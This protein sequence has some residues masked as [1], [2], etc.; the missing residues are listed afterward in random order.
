MRATPSRNVGGRAWG[1]AGGGC[2]GGARSRGMEQ[3]GLQLGTNL[4]WE[5]FTRDSPFILSV[6][7]VEIL[8]APESQGAAR[9]TPTPRSCTHPSWMLLIPPAGLDPLIT[10]STSLMKGPWRKPWCES[11]PQVMG[12]PWGRLCWLLKPWWISQDTELGHSQLDQGQMLHLGVSPT[13]QT[14]LRV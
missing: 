9:Q 6:V 1:N 10:S 2:L 3:V 14:L 12:Q 5:E 8:Q 13:L 7:S 4:L 11:C